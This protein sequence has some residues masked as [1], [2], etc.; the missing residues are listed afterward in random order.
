MTSPSRSDTVIFINKPLSNVDLLQ[1]V[2]QLG[3]KNFRG[4][5]SCGN[6]PDQIKQNERGLIN[7]DSQIGPGT[8]WVH[9]YRNIDQYCEYFDS[10]GLKMPRDIQRYLTTSGKQIIHL[11]DEIQEKDSV[12][13]GYWCL[14][15]LNER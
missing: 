14:C 13:C 10:F 7:L 8:H 11:G 4:I 15:Y 6:L 3:I 5:F 2:K 9:G 12:L 1:W